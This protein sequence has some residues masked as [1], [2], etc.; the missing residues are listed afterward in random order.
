MFRA[1]VRVL[2]KRKIRCLLGSTANTDWLRDMPT[3]QLEHMFNCLTY[4]M[5]K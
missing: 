2:I 4:G 1:R 3:A 5:K